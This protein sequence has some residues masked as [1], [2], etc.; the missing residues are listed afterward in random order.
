MEDRRL[1]R[2][3]RL[4]GGA[5]RR[6]RRAW[7]RARRLDRLAT[8]QAGVVPGGVTSEAREEEEVLMARHVGGNKSPRYSL[9]KVKQMVT[10]PRACK[11]ARRRRVEL[12]EGEWD[13]QISS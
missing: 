1:G 10:R 12:G 11:L 2:S 7:R 3:R 13:M 5:G 9:A 4:G 6:S 8:R